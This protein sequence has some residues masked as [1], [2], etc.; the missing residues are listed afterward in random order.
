VRHREDRRTLVAV[1]AAVTATVA[2]AFAWSAW[3]EA[4]T[5]FLKSVAVVYRAEGELVASD[6]WRR[7]PPGAAVEAAAV[8]G[9]AQRGGAARHLCAL[10]PVEVGGVRVEVQPI[11]AWPGGYGELRATW[12]TVEPAVFGWRAV[13]AATAE[14]L[15]HVDLL[16][17]ELGHGLLARP[18]LE[19]H[20]DDF[21]S[22]P[23][24]GNT[25]PAG[26]LRLKVRVGVYRRPT[27]VL[28]GQAVS[29]PGAPDLLAGPGPAIVAGLPTL[30][31]IDPT[32]AE[33]LRLGCFTFAAG[34][35]PDG[36]PGWPLPLSPQELVSRRLIATPEG[37]A[38]VAAAGD[39][40]A[41][42]WS[43]PV[44]L[45]VKGSEMRD[46]ALSRRI[47]WGAEVR[48]GDAVT[49]G[50]RWAALVAD[51]GDGVLS[52]GDRA[53]FAWL[54]PARFASLAEALG[55]PEAGDPLAL[56]RR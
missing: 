34:V 9:F 29:S 51:D 26:P 10:S 35:W 53:L 37:V 22:A 16:A 23:V 2:G 44:G 6:R 42:P 52:L 17:P 28:P 18:T 12:F 1:L 36:G 30:A 8:V 5:P 13:S 11:A 3:R 15:R 48:P 20:N 21:L 46:A 33:L 4:G 25:I 45:E 40:L 43:A 55:G 50:G 19:A 54:A 27:D 49:A 39:P 41:A 47:R 31:G 38:A 32:V 56:R 24:A 14:M 7:L